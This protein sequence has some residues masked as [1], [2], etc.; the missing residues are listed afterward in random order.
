MAFPVVFSAILVTAQVNSVVGGC[1]MATVG[2]VMF[3][4]ITILAVLVQPFAAVAVTVYVPGADT[5]V[6]AVVAP[7]LQE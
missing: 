1:V 6:F 4:E 2:G 3:C 5:E 7:L